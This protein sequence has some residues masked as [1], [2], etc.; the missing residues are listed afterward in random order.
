MRTVLS[1]ALTAAAAVLVYL[2]LVVPDA[3]GRMKEGTF[4]AGAF[5]R[6]PIE[7]IIGGAI[8]L[9]LSPRW[10]RP[11]AVLLGLGLGAVV[12]LKI[13][14][15]GFRQVL[16][17]RF[18]VV[19]DPPLFKDG[20]NA[21][22]ETDG[23]TYAMLAVVGAVLLTLAA[24]AV[25][26]LAVLRLTR[27]TARYAGPARRGLV[28]LTAVWLALAI[29]G[30]TLFP[31]AP[32]ASDSA[33]DLLKATAKSV[34][35]ALRDQ[36]KFAATAQNDPFRGV[37]PADLVSGLA[38]KDVV[39]GVVESYGRSA[40]TDPAMS[41]VVGPVL[42][43]D[44]KKLA[45][46]GFAARSGWLTSS[47]YGGGSWLAHAS[48]QSGLWINSQQRYRQLT[49]GNRITLTSAFHDAG[50]QTV[51]M[52]PGNT[53]AWPESSFYG[54]DEVYDSRN[55]GYTG[56]RFGWS[57]MPDQYTLASFQKNAY[58]KRT[59]PLMAE[60]TMTSSHEPWT[61]IP[62]TVDWDQI[63]DGSIYKPMAA[64]TLSRNTLWSNKPKTR[65]QYAKSIGYSVDNLIS[66]ATRYGN[67]NLVVVMFGDHQ[68]IPL[69]SGENAS[70]DVPVTIIAHDPKVLDR[71]A[72]WHWADGLR[73]TAATPVWRMDQFRDK[74]FT[75]Y[76]AEGGTAL[77]AH[78]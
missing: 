25:C 18:D 29:S 51:G 65:D 19:L 71:L 1:A 34:P 41:A 37:P 73:P 21:L 53:V 28:G 68:P 75:A 54:Y 74:F 16:G 22:T 60:I 23:R 30:I 45:A 3:V 39:I 8:L 6:V 33:A 40:L 5:L 9:V 72:D 15:V 58:A 2:A 35:T 20:Y 55:M 10:R 52:E 70:H 38:G 59:K 67:Q 61:N 62:D 50:W 77:P 32:V 48:F 57:R 4:V 76:R 13:V 63:G 7:I 36:R 14:N 42:A 31:N 47:T 17:R 11:V 24:L 27:A 26:T 46:A 12:V 49:A 64:K 43:A 44:E 66:W 69:V 78:R 56:P